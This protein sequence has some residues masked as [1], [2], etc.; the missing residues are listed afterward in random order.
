MCEGYAKAFQYLMNEI[1]IDNVI[2]IGT[3]TNSN[4]QTENHAWNYV[5][6][7]EKW[8]AVDTTWDDPILIGEGTLPE[9]SRYQYFLKGSATMNQNHVTSG[10]FTD[11]GQVFIYPRLNTEDYE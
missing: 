5:K 7:N 8:Y 11:A 2:V 1:G 4:G 10:K 9:K 3:A 6:L